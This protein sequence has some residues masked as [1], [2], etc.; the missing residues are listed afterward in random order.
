MLAQR[1]I[2]GQIDRGSE[3]KPH[4]TWLFPGRFSEAGND[5]HLG[6]STLAQALSR[7]SDLG[8]FSEG[9]RPHDLRR[10]LGSHIGLKH[11][12]ERS[13]NALRHA[14][15]SVIGRHYI[16]GEGRKQIAAD[17]EEWSQHVAQQLEGL[18]DDL[19]PPSEPTPRL[20]RDI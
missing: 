14:K 2:Q 18:I 13:A 8:R 15:K 16:V 19:T 1:L 20:G 12:E 11:G 10:T 3:K 7:A 6:A 17:L 5:T 9:V 4:T